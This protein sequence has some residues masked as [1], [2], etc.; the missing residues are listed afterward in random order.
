MIKWLFFDLGSTLID[1]TDCDEFRLRQLLRQPG[2]PERKVI[3]QA[4]REFS[5]QNRPAYK[6]TVKKFGLEAAK[7]PTHLEKLY[8]GVPEMLAKLRNSYMLG[9][10][11]NQSVGTEQRMADFG[12]RQYFDVVISSAELGVAKPDPAIFLAALRAAECPAHQA[13]MIGDRLDNDIQP[14]GKLGMFTVWVRQGSGAA[15]TPALMEKPP[16]RIVLKIDEIS[17]IFKTVLDCKPGL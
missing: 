7:W 2:A 6:E 4:M 11:A 14:A 13:A 8:P 9:I 5:A 10:I 17:G 16:D 1:E 3:E 15:G 12:I